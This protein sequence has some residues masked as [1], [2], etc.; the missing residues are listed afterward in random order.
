MKFAS[1]VSDSVQLLTAVTE[2]SQQVRAQLEGARADLVCLFV[3][4]IY[5]A[6]WAEALA[7]VHD[8]LRP[9]VVVGCSAGG[10]IGG[11]QEFE[12]VPAVSMLGA[13][14][15]QVRLLP[16]HIKP[17]ELE[18]ASPGG[19]W[20]DKLGAVPSDDPSILLFADPYTC[21]A[22]ALLQQLNATYPH[23]PII[24][25]LV[26]GGNEAGEH[27]LLY[28][29]DVFREGAVGVALTGNVR[30]EAIIS[31]G[32]RPIGKPFVITKAEENIVWE[33]G[34][35]QTLEV[36]RDV[37]SGLSSGDQELAQRAIFAGVAIDEMKAQFRS[38]DF[39]IR[40]LVGIDPPSG[41]IAVSESVHI[42]QT[43]QFHLRDPG[44]SKEELRRLLTERTAQGPP[45]GAL[46]FDCLGRGKSFYGTANHDVKA[47]RAVFGKQLPLAGF[48]SNGEIGPVGGTNFLHGYTASIGLFRPAVA[49]PDAPS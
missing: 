42:G 35:R 10:V 7:H 14:L 3:S 8:V 33:L 22:H 18:A 29:T 36:L 30:V 24:G 20:I 48:F 37:L 47:L 49:E 25:G 23:R 32:C 16:F 26:S 46:M 6:S 1:G 21:D 43:M 27:V 44:S 31:Q 45:A 2:A 38:G 41:A 9:A 17:E 11:E 4:P 15:P 34:G 39:L 28:D 5:R 12:W 13:S 40:Q 19:F